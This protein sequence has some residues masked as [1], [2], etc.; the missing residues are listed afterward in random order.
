MVVTTIEETH[1]AGAGSLVSPVSAPSADSVRD[2]GCDSG[3]G[4]GGIG[5]VTV[6]GVCW[7][8]EA[9]E[10]VGSFFG[11]DEPVSGKVGNEGSILHRA[12]T[13]FTICVSPPCATI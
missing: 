10:R 12:N 2:S 3:A 11:V 7:R 8:E 4:L 1:G 13:W 6:G 9:G 5:E